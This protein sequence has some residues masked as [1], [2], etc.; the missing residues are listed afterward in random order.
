MVIL[1]L[2]VHNHLSQKVGKISGD[3]ETLSGVVETHEGK[4]SELE[5]KVNYVDKGTLYDSNNPVYGTYVG[6]AYKLPKHS[7]TYHLELSEIAHS[8][9]ALSVRLVIFAPFW[10]F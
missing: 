6:V 3:V 5:L 2:N 1:S 9:S 8:G 4:L 7:I 10:E